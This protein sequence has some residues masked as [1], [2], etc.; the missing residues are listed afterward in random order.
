VLELLRG[1]NEEHQSL[2]TGAQHST[3]TPYLVRLPPR[4]DLLRKM[5]QL[6]WGN[7]WGV[8][9]TCPLSL[10]ELRNYYRTVLMVT[11]PDGTELFSRFY[12]P[13]FFRRF[14]E[15]CSRDEAEK[16][17]GPVSAY[18]MEDE[19]PEILLEF[20]KSNTGTEKRG[21]LLSALT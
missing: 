14:L 8:Y 11:M 1:A 16:F 10:A 20:I 15:T 5:I 7:E 3:I 12:D 6:G 18:F 13:R 19:R 9:L 17:F 2:Y 21:Q 4:C